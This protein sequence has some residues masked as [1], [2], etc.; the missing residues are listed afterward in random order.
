MQSGRTPLGLRRIQQVTQLIVDATIELATHDEDLFA[1]YA[2][3]A[4]VEQAPEVVEGARR[5]IREAN[6]IKLKEPRSEAFR[7]AIRRANSRTSS[8]P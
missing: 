8:R 2:R 6:A 7:S 1:H 4:G 3:E 5:R